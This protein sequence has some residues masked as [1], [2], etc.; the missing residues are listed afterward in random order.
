MSL[1]SAIIQYNVQSDLRV[2]TAS[3]LLVM[4]SSGQTAVAKALCLV[5][6]WWASRFSPYFDLSC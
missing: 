4:L 6:F 3:I 5:P 2:V 1:L